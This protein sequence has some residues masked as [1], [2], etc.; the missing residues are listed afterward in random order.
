MIHS[1]IKKDI[2]AYL[3]DIF[4]ERNVVLAHSAM[5]SMKT[6]ISIGGYLISGVLFT[7]AFELC[8]GCVCFYKQIQ[9]CAILRKYIIE[10][11]T[12]SD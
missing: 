3:S 4:Y 5:Q 8:W 2:A 10:S 9:V 12:L 7:I 6:D 11:F 1:A